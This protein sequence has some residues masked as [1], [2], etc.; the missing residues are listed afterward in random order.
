MFKVQALGF[1]LLIPTLLGAS[2]LVGIGLLNNLD[3]AKRYPQY[4]LRNN[5]VVVTSGTTSSGQFKF[6]AGRARM[7]EAAYVVVLIVL[8]LCLLVLCFLARLHYLRAQGHKGC[9]LESSGG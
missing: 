9:V 3:E 1:G 7:V 4:W 5:A 8:A 6:N 2:V